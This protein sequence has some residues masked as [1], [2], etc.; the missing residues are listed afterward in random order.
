MYRE[1]IAEAARARGWSVADYDRDDVARTAAAID[2][3]LRA[4]RREAGPPWTADHRLAATAALTA[5][6]LARGDEQSR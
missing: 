3:A 4:I 2:P 5:L 1:A 6:G